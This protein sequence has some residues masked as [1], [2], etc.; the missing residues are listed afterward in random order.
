MPLISIDGAPAPRDGKHPILVFAEGERML[1]LV[2]DE[3]VDIVEGSLDLQL[4]GSTQPGIL[5]SSI[6]AGR[7]TDVID[8]VYY[9][10][11][12]DAAWFEL[13]THEPFGSESERKVLL[14]EDSSFFRNLLMP[15]LKMA[16]YRVTVA[17]HGEAA[18]E[19]CR[20]GEE[21]DLIIS[22]IEMPGLSGF[23]LARTLRQEERWKDV[24]MV[25]LSSHAN[26]QDFERGR[27][28]GFNDYVTKLDP[29]ALL[30]SLSR[31]LSNE[32]MREESAA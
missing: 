18:L 11:Q 5:G 10:R 31:V 17:E 30:T 8:T 24:P 9:L 16:G 2:V 28:S 20:D 14:V 7:S 23:D 29:K 27:N 12:S 26:P 3:V 13:Q 22:D 21:F 32:D 4:V 1:G 19:I 25:A 6:I 15:M